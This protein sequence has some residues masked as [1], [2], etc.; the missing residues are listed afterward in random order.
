MSLGNSSDLMGH[1][2][3]L[4]LLCAWEG[5]ENLDWGQLFVG[6]TGVVGSRLGVR[7]VGFLVLMVPCLHHVPLDPKPP[8][9]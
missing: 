4:L 6:P 9:S 5:P 2:S 7:R 8:A 1:A 3:E